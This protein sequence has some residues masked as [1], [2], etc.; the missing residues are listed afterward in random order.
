MT[1]IAMSGTR[2]CGETICLNEVI[3]LSDELFSFFFCCL[4]GAN[5]QDGWIDIDP[6]KWRA[7]WDELVAER[8]LESEAQYTQVAPSGGLF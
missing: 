4:F 5:A 2:D 1:K 8:T 7:N 3:R 6:D